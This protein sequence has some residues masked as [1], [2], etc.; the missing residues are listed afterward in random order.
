MRVRLSATA[1]EQFTMLPKAVRAKAERQFVY[2]ACDIRHPSL[3]AKKYK[4]YVDVWQA[5]IDRT[6][7]FYFHI[8][9]PHCVV[10]SI[11]AHPK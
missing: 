10:V 8:I 7:R 11:I 9:E 5:R 2:L 1:M 6:W 4:G 3:R